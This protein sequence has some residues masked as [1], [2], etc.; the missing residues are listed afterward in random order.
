MALAAF[1]NQRMIRED[2]RCNGPAVSIPISTEPY[3]KMISWKI[4]E[5]NAVGPSTPTKFTAWKWLS[6][7]HSTTVASDPHSVSTPYQ[8]LS[9]QALVLSVFRSLIIPFGDV[10]KA[11]SGRFQHRKNLTIGW[12]GFLFE[13]S[14]PPWNEMITLPQS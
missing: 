7:R 2:I 8:D 11:I 1:Q 13:Q 3:L 14:G 10:R 6:I 9:S 4:L 5:I 12:L